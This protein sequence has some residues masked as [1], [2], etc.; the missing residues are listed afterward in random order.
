MIFDFQRAD[1]DNDAVLTEAEFV[2]G[3]PVMSEVVL[4]IGPVGSENKMN[5][6]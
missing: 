1:T 3:L 6:F 4:F 5:L 2:S